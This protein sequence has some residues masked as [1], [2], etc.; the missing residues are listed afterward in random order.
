M[1]A[2]DEPAG[3]AS[4]DVESPDAP[5]GITMTRAQLRF[6]SWTTDV[7][8]YT[9]VLNLFV[10][11]A[12]AV[13]IDHYVG[14][15]G[16]PDGSRTARTPLPAAMERALPGS[17]ELAYRDRIVAIAREVL[18]GRVGVGRDGFAGRYLD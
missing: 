12:D 4:E 7:L 16:S 3:P 10:E 6:A 8:V 2:P 13:V 1:T 17:S 15:D 11:Y 14:G 5:T 9:V 18:P